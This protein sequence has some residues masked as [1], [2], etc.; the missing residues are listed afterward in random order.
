MLTITP[1]GPTQAVD[2]LGV[3]VEF[4]IEPSFPE[5]SYCVLKGTIPAGMVVPLHSH[6]DDESFFV[7]S[8]E[9]DVLKEREGGQLEWQ[10]VTAGDFVHIAGGMKHA[11]RNRSKS[12]VVELVMTT[13]L[14]G[15]FFQEVGRPLSS[16][17]APPTG[18][19][20]ERFATLAAQYGH[21]LA[22]PSENARF[23]LDMPKPARQLDRDEA[24]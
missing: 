16:A 4:L 18:Q 6:R 9:A 11:H 24:L 19:E 10:R 22:S 17:G 2:V 23:G 20:L 1:Q 15:R 13:S 3:R 7:V 8:G 5:V 21:W 12:A 14:L